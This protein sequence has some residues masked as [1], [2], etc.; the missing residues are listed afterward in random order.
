MIRGKI[1]AAASRK[2]KL[3]QEK[4]QDSQKQLKQ[5]ESSHARNQNPATLE[6]IKTLRNKI[7]LMYTREIEKK[8]LFSRQRYYEN[9]PKFT[10]LLAWKL[11]KRQAD[12][13][14]YKI[15]DPQKNTLGSKQDKIQSIFETFN[16]QLFSKT[17]DVG[18][19]QMDT[20]LEMLNLP[21]MSKTQNKQLASEITEK[22]LENA[23]RYLKA[24]KSPGSD[25]F[26]SKFYKA[27]KEDLI[28]ILRKT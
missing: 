4:L 20:F 7:N 27:F 2:K 25:G 11:K 1:I 5:L 15:R 21:T 23:I 3:F 19:D 14:I 17:M 9:G 13:T 10:K 22:E 18:P 8:V 26:T 12:N 24:N 6:R 16:K 28:P